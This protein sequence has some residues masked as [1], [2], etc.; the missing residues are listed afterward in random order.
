MVWIC[1]KL[2]YDVQS[3]IHI[4]DNTQLGISN[5][6]RYYILGKTMWGAVTA[7]LSRWYMV[8]YDPI[9]Y[10]KI[11]NFVKK[12]LIFSY[13]FPLDKNK[14]ILYPNYT[15]EGIVYG[16]NDNDSKISEGEFE[17]K[18]I[19][20]Y[21]STSVETTEEGSLHEI[22]HLYPPM[23]IGYVFINK[24][25]SF[26]NKSLLKVKIQ[27][28]K[29]ILIIGKYKKV[30]L[31]NLLDS[32]QVGGERSYGFGRLKRMNKSNPEMV[33]KIYNKSKVKLDLN[34]PTL[35][36]DIAFSHLNFPETEEVHNNKRVIEIR[37]EFE[38]LVWRD[39]DNV[40][41]CGHQ[42]EFCT[43]ALVPGST[44]KPQKVKI[45]EFGI[46]SFI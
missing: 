12:N 5:R 34:Y 45:R 17:A 7:I 10:K 22:E 8:K 27:D 23:F 21:V 16:K 44:F 43:V 4:G 1:F 3:P 31:F 29:K 24:D 26:Q 41:G 39:W 42:K 18:F 6:T 30:E 9:I 46:W 35:Q 2:I 20:S 19:T 13:F 33:S 36:T 14:H 28:D 37:G 40:K 15:D 38:P 25:Q 32:I 11:G